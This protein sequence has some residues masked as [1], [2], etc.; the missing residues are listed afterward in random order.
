MRRAELAVLI[1][2]LLL[3]AGCAGWFSGSDMEQETPGPAGPAATLPTSL[4]GTS[5]GMQWWYEQ[6]DGAGQLFGIP[7]ADTGCGNCH[8]AT[9][10]QCHTNGLTAEGQQ[11]FVR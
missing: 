7:Y 5:G 3:A 9:C 4:H 2:C 6:D 1:S 8:V 11:T 10:D